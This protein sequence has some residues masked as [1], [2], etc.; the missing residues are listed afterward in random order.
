MRARCLLGVLVLVLVA[1]VALRGTATE[2][3]VH[4]TFGTLETL[5]GHAATEAAHGVGMAMMELSWAAYEPARDRFDEAYARAA[6]DRLHGY[7]TAGLRVTL[8]LGL[9]YPPDWVLAAP[10]S[11]FVDQHGARSPG[12][13]LVFNQR[14]RDL[15]RAYLSRL[16]RDLDLRRFSAIRLTSGAEPEVLYPAGG[17]YWAFDPAAQNGPGRPPTLAPNPLPGWRPGDRSVSTAD[18]RRWADWYVRALADVVTWQMRELTA[19]GFTGSYQILTPGVGSRPAEYDRDIAAYLPDSITGVGAVWHLLYASLPPDERI[20]VYVS[21]MADE[22]G[23]A[24]TCEPG[25]RR[26]PLDDPRTGAW[27]ATRWLARVAGAH[28]FRLNGENPGLNQPA[29]LNRHYADTSA[30]GMMTA[31]VREMVSCG[32]EGMYWAHDQQLWDGTTAFDRYAAL[33]AQAN[34]TQ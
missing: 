19:A 30:A 33:I 17:S 2:S 9:H 21:S 18:V 1:V 15:A 8:G 24:H 32:F 20:V 25:D 26:V 10:D 7:E 31:S 6:R 29:R 14:L 28:G 27:P 34:G 12:V 13:N 5:P 4:Y 3:G 16:A 11:R 22:P 23:R